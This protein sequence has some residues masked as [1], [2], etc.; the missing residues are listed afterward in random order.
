MSASGVAAQKKSWTRSDRVKSTSLGECVRLGDAS[1]LRLALQEHGVGLHAAKALRVA[2]KLGQ[3]ECV[4]VL[5]QAGCRADG[6]G[7]GGD[8][9]AMR[10]AEFGRDECLE[11]LVAA[12][13]DVNARGRGEARALKLAAKY[14]HARCVAILAAAGAEV[15]ARY[16]NAMTAAMCAAEAGQAESLRVLVSAG[17]DLDARNGFGLTAAMLAAQK[18]RE[19]CLAVLVAAGCRLELESAG[20]SALSLAKQGGW[21]QCAGLI[22]SEIARREIAKSVPGARVAAGGARGSWL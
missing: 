10:A 5:L 14:G 20:R 15:D 22:E 21:S 6:G 7:F 19:D 18:G 12:G 13:C 9:P 17:C 2:A 4:D 16:E 11:R 8:P 1:G 3:A